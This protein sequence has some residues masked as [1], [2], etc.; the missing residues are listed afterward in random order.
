M[1][2]MPGVNDIEAAMAM[3]HDPPFSAGGRAK[4]KQAI[5]RAEFFFLGHIG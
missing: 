2:D 4:G 5:D 3:N 1:L